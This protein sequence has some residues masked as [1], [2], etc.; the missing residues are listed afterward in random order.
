MR[1]C[2]EGLRDVQSNQV[3]GNAESIGPMQLVRQ[4]VRD[5]LGSTPFAKAKGVFTENTLRPTGQASMDDSLTNT[6]SRICEVHRTPI[7][8]I[9]SITLLEEKNQFASVQTLWTLAGETLVD[10][11]QQ[12]VEDVGVR[13]N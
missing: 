3:D 11:G 12:E 5:V 9:C 10:K 2:V 1:S 4:Q 7:R 8:R 13:L 6:E